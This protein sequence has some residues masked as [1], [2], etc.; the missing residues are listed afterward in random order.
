MLVL[1]RKAG[2]TIQIGPDVSVTVVKLSSGAVRLGIV[3]PPEMAVV[4]GEL[5][6][7]IEAELEV[8]TE[9]LRIFNGDK[10]DQ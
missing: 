8:P 1:S 2:Q 6:A 4:R 7:E 5:A 10:A 9:P 3:A